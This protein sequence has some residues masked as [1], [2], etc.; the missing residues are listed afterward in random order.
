MHLEMYVLIESIKKPLGISGVLTSHSAWSKRG[1][2]E[3]GSQID[4]IIT[5]S[6]HVINMCEL[7]YYSKPYKVNKSDYDKIIKREEL[8][9]SMIAPREVVHSTLITTYEP[10]R[11]EYSGVFSKVITLDDLFA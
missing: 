1:D 6:D 8:L 10:E 7:K 2:D 5:R 9:A 3:D 11:N 4:L